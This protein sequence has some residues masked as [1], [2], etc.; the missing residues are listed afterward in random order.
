M[1]SAYHMAMCLKE[2]DFSSLLGRR[3]VGNQEGR[4][5]EVDTFPSSWHKIAQRF[6]VYCLPSVLHIFA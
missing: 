6:Q 5:R 3:S 2:S 4:F 1:N